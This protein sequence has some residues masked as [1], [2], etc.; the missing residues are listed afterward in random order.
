MAGKPLTAKT[1]LEGQAV[2][3]ADVYVQALTGLTDNVQ[4]EALAAE[5]DDLVGVLAASGG[6]A[7]LF[8][9]ASRPEARSDWVQHVFHGR[10]SETLEAL[11]AFMA[12]KGRLALL[13]LV[14]RRFRAALNRREGR[15]EVTVVSARELDE[16]HRRAVAE[17]LRD[18]TGAE[19]LLRTRVDPSLL[20]GLKVWIGDREYDGSLAGEL[21]RLRQRLRAAAT[22]SEPPGG[23]PSDHE[24]QS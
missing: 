14:A 17:T 15:V 19:P 1:V 18:V 3:V 2:A 5:L 7:D 11:L 9:A 10:C 24:A 16:P 12:R 6:A 4:A 20:G 13:P 21:R 22:R 23:E 8:G